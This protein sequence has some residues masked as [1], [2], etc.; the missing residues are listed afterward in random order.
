MDNRLDALYGRQSVDKKGSISIESQL[1]FCEYGLRD[2]SCKKYTDKG[3]SGKTSITKNFKPCYAALNIVFAQLE[4]ET[5]QM[6]MTGNHYSRCEKGFR[7]S[8]KAFLRL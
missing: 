7:A 8:E 1:E 4:Q 5:I 6:R 2:F 3:Y